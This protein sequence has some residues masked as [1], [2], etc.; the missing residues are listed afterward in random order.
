MRPVSAMVLP[1]AD[2]FESQIPRY[3]RAQR[4]SD[5]GAESGQRSGDI[6]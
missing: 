1:E 5:G 6:P 4:V 2:E 3:D